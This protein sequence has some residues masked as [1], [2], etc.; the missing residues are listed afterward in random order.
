VDTRIDRALAEADRTKADNA[1][2]ISADKL[3]TAQEIAEFIGEPLDRT[4]YLIRN[5]LIPFG[6]EGRRIIASRAALRAHYSKA[7]SS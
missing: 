2:P 6:R 3:R 1:P 5:R 7:T 4:R